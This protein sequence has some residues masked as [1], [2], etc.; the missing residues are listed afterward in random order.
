MLWGPHLLAVQSLL[1]IPSLLLA[2][3][4][5]GASLT[6]SGS[7]SELVVAIRDSASAV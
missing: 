7:V 5:C 1:L 3:S 2:V 4:F 6:F